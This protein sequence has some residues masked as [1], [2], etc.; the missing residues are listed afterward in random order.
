M[1]RARRAQATVITYNAT[2]SARDEGQADAAR[3]GAAPNWQAAVE[4]LRPGSSGLG[5]AGSADSGY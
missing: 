1:R 4:A 5:S 3:T 2:L